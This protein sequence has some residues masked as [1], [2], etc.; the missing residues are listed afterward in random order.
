MNRRI[1]L[2]IIGSLPTGLTLASGPSLAAQ[3]PPV[4]QPS[5]LCSDQPDAAIATFEAL[6]HL[7][8]RIS[9]ISTL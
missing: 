7:N 3:V 4:L 8:L 1:M 9:Q 6:V 2:L 5:A